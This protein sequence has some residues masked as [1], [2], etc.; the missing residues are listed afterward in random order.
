[1]DVGHEVLWVIREC[2]SGEVLL[3]RPLLSATESDL[4]AL[5]REVLQMLPVPVV[6]V[7]SDGQQSLRKAVAS[8][9]PG[10]PHQLCQFHYLR[11]AGHFIFEAD[12]H[13]KKELKKQVRGVR[14]L[15]PHGL[16]STA[17]Q[18]P[19][20]RTAFGWLHQ[21]AHLLNNSSER[22]VPVLRQA[23]R[24]LLANMHQGAQS[25]GPLESAVRHFLKVTASY[26]P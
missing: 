21:A 24:R 13:A 15:I 2:L 3:A 6:G 19:A 10:V 16:G 25:A 11:E 18:W 1:P 17:D 14:H 22:K 23:Y 9:L 5:F 8:A 12:R 7:I 26:W 4:A 20:I